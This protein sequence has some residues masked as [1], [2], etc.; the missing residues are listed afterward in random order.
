[1]STLARSIR[2]RSPR[3]RTPALPKVV[4]AT[5]VIAELERA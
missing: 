2:W 1:M 3:S 5:G 4:C